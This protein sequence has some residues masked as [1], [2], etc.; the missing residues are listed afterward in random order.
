MR[1]PRPAPSSTHASPA[2]K[3]A[4][5]AIASSASSSPRKFWPHDFFGA[6][7]CRRRI[8]FGCSIGRS[9]L[10]RVDVQRGRD[11][12]PRQ[13]ARADFPHAACRQPS[14]ASL[15]QSPLGRAAPLVLRV[16]CFDTGQL[17]D[18]VVGLG[19]AGHA[20]ARLLVSPAWLEAGVLPSDGV[21][22]RHHRRDYDPLGLPLRSSRFR[23]RLMRAASLLA[24][25]P[26]RRASRVQHRSS[27]AC[28]SPRGSAPGLHAL[29]DGAPR[30]TRGCVFATHHARQCRW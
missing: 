5:R 29:F 2:L 23:H 22:L 12:T 19:Q 25:Q 18:G 6:R 7:R 4:A 24:S 26:R 8:D 16:W 21:P 27:L 28:C 11:R 30:P 9:C 17:L 14:S 20:L 15:R 1:C 13:S 3:P 10:L